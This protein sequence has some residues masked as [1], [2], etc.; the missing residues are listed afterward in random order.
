MRG[1]A[2]IDANGII[3][4][5][6]LFEYVRDNVKRATDY[7]QHPFIGSNA[8]DRNLPIALVAQSYRPHKV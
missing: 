1:A 6:E 8:F 5:G 4:I 7:K 3:T 2:D